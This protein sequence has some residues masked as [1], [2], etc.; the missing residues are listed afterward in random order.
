MN[1]EFDFIV[2]VDEIDDVIDGLFVEIGS[3][4]RKEYAQG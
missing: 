4:R 3:K 2:D 1:D